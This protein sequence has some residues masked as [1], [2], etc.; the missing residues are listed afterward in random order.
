MIHNCKCN[1]KTHIFIGCNLLIGHEDTNG[2]SQLQILVTNH[3]F[4][5]HII[6]WSQLPN[7]G[8]QLYFIQPAP[9]HHHGPHPKCFATSVSPTPYHDT[10]T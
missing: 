5:S 6:Y 2:R 1:H 7:S 9:P 3:T 10:T 8:L 4:L